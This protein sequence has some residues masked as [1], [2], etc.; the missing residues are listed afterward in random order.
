MVYHKQ[1]SHVFKVAIPVSNSQIQSSRVFIISS[2]SWILPLNFCCSSWKQNQNK[3]QTPKQNNVNL[4][5]SPQFCI[6][7]F[8]SKCV[9]VLTRFACK[10]FEY[11]T[12]F[13][14]CDWTLL[15]FLKKLFLSFSLAPK[16]FSCWFKQTPHWVNCE[17]RCQIHVTHKCTAK[18]NS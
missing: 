4:I 5:L 14:S 17:N 7:V 1:E 6:L 9:E 3:K 18:A 10:R 8:F 16:D 13:I 11:R 15:V 2:A 12:S